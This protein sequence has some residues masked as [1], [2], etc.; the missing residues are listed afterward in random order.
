MNLPAISIAVQRPDGTRFDIARGDAVFEHGIPVDAG[1]RFNVGSVAKQITAYLVLQAARKRKIDLTDRVHTLL[2]KYAV[3]DITVAELITHT[4]GIRDTEAM[5]SLCGYRELD[6]YTAAD[7]LN[8]SYRQ[9]Q[10]SSPPDQFLYSNT[11]YLLLAAILESAHGAPFPELAE[12]AVFRPLGMADTAFR[13]D[14]R[15]PVTHAASSYD[16]DGANI[17]SGMRPVAIA[18]PGS[19]WTTPT[20]LLTWLDHLFSSVA[21]CWPAQL[22]FTTE[23][24]YA[25]CGRGHAYGP[26]LFA[27]NT[28]DR[29]ALFHNGHEHSY[30]ASTYLRSDGLAV[31]CV[32]NAGWIRADQIMAELIRTHC[33]PE[34]TDAVASKHLAGSPQ[35]T[36]PKA[37]TRTEQPSEDLG[38]YHTQE[39]PGFIRLGRHTSGLSIARR[40]TIDILTP[41]PKSPRRFRAPGIAVTVDNSGPHPPHDF[42]LD[43]DRAPGLHY[44]RNG[45]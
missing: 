16:A 7:L 24:T 20:D 21:G 10:R 17:V 4:S 35:S 38:R 42:V 29:P 26:G 31:A 37:L 9:R 12:T 34:N 11:N 3:D 44:V 22:P 41:D 45:Q 39:L 19:L 2:P 25:Q 15:A 13:S 33:S 27:M 30:S 36:S 14:P 40:G 5:L 18:G 8:L 43:L 23:L 32:T 28:A 1:T 6:H